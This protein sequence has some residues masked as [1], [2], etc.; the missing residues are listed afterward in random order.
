[1]ILNFGTFDCVR[2]FAERLL[3]DDITEEFSLR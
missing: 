1:M 2:G 3:W